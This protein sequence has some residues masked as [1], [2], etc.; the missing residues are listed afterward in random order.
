MRIHE[1]LFLTFSHCPCPGLPGPRKEL[2]YLL[3][4]Q[5]LL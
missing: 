4:V 1:V 2:V 3:C 5:Y